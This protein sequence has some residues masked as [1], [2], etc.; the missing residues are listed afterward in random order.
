MTVAAW[1]PGNVRPGDIVDY[2]EM[3]QFE[4]IGMLQRGMT[5]RAPPGR[6]VILMS[7]RKDAPYDDVLDDDGHLI[8][9]GHD[10]PKSAA[11]PNP[12]L[13]DQPRKSVAGRLTDNGKFADWTDRHKNGEVPAALFHVF[14]KMRDGIWS[15][16]GPFLLKDYRYE[17]SGERFVFRF[18]LDAVEEVG[19][20]LQPRPADHS[21][22]Q[23]RQIPTWVKQF[24]YKRDRG[25][26]VLCGSREQLH[27]DHDLPYS[28]GGSSATPRNVR[29]LCAKHN[30]S[31]GARIE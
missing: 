23:S 17:R 21:E 12:K 19:A 13:A 6:G 22:I 5:F 27:F 10:A 31:K 7:Q 2:F 11:A 26:C 18:V 30:L 15:F 9:E 24:V 25:V 20:D 4:G 28:L 14:E 8:Y 29:L 3:C 16:R 1:H